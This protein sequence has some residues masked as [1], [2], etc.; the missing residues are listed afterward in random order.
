MGKV[1]KILFVIAA[2]TVGLLI[3][4]R[5]VNSVF[6]YFY[7][8]CLVGQT[9]GK[10]NYYLEKKQLP[11]LLIMGNSRAFY[12]LNPDSFKV[13]KGFNISHAGMDQG[14]QNGLFSIL[15][16]KNKMPSQVLLHVE[17]DFLL[18]TTDEKV[19]SKGVQQLKYYY[20][21][22]P[23]VTEY[24]NELG[25][26][27]F[28]KYQLKSY[29][30][31]GRVINIALNFMSTRV[32]PEATGNGFIPRPVTNL[33]SLH[34]EYTYKNRVPGNVSL[35][36]TATRYIIRFLEMAKQNNIH[37]DCFTSPMYYKRNLDYYKPARDFLDSLF[38]ANSVK[39]IDY[40][41]IPPQD[42]RI[43]DPHFWED[44]EHLNGNG[45]A[46][47]SRQVAEDFRY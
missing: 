11:D 30:F 47:F 36:R 8:K 4:D 40:E 1:R 6:D 46:I 18:T 32:N 3:V 27:E 9:G 12:M 5:V 21:I 35:N 17:P 10:I 33:D 34:T 14:F 16:G 2:F 43:R 45:A 41:R 13:K 7:N 37:V 39:Y 19:V 20:G 38:Q 25:P 26:F 23:V 44:S 15:I 22:D 28:L 31:N 24:L 42:P 29:R